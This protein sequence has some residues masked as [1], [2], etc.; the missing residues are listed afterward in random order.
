MVK[1]KYDIVAA[2]AINA[3][4]AAT[5]LSEGEYT[6][7]AIASRLRDVAAKQISIFQDHYKTQ[8][9]HSPKSLALSQQLRNIALQPPPKCIT[10]RIKVCRQD[11]LV[12][13]SSV[14]TNPI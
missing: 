10:Q 2:S 11:S 5:A 12:T 7:R 6:S 4:R 14:E 8:R 13:K 3:S 1:N 9:S